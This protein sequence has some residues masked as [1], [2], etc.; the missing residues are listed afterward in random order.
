[1]SFKQNLHKT[2]AVSHVTFIQRNRERQN[3]VADLQSYREI[4]IKR[5]LME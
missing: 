2:M 3:L 5:R 1:M 4:E